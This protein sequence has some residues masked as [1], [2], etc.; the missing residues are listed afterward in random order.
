MMVVGH[1]PGMHE[2]ALGLTGSGEP[3]SQQA[4]A[5]N[6]TA[7]LMRR[8]PLSQRVHHK[9]PEAIALALRGAAGVAFGWLMRPLRPQQPRLRD[10]QG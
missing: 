9:A 7:R 3:A 8:D 5:E 6:L 1:N 2:L 10:R 4:L